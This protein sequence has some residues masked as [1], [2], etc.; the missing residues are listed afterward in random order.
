[1]NKTP[2]PIAIVLILGSSAIATAGSLEWV[3]AGPYPTKSHCQP[4][5]F[6]QPDAIAVDKSKN[7]YIANEAG[8]NAVQEVTAGGAGTIRTVLSRSVEPIKS[9]HYFGLSLA[10]DPQAHLYLAV[11]DRG[12]VE[13]LNADGNLTVIAGSPGD[14]RLIDGPPPK[15]RLKAPNAI[16]IDPQGTI[17]VADTRTIRKISPGGATATLAGNPYAKNPNPVKGGSPWYVDGRGRRAVF[18]SPDGI[19]ADGSGMFMWQTDMADMMRVERMMLGSFE[20]S[21]PMVSSALMRGLRFTTVRILTVKDER[22]ASNPYRG[23][24]TA[25][26]AIYTSPRQT[27]PLFA[28]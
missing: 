14:R 11:K 12:T 4:I 13:R 27:R 1:M 19:A 18:M 24:P 22:R 5:S 23:S 20:K 17:Y 21:P 28:E 8:P 3:P 16:A 6:D 26:W 7:I 2:F 10:F 9:G 15:A 25:R